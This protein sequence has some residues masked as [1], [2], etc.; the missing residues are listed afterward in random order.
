[1]IVAEA[2]LRAKGIYNSGTITI[3]NNEVDG[4]FSGD[5]IKIIKNG[6]NLLCNLSEMIVTI[7]KNGKVNKSTNIEIYK[8]WYRRDEVYY[9]GKIQYTFWDVLNPDKYLNI[10]IEK[11][12]VND[13]AAVTEE[14]EDIIATS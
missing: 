2:T 4:F 11:I 7:D 14:A 9:P 13:E 1:M 8:A 5:K 6:E 12:L 10:F 3:Q